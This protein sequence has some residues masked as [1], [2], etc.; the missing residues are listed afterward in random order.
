[1][2][3]LKL[4]ITDHKTPMHCDHYLVRITSSQ[5]EHEIKNIQVYFGL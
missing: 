1:M 4:N 5:I 3:I 2:K